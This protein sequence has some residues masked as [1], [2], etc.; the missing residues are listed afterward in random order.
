[1]LMTQV[2]G[3]PVL[4]DG[5]WGEGMGLTCSSR[6]GQLLSLLPAARAP[7]ADRMPRHVKEGDL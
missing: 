3:W 7:G 6:A 5:H 4:L 2:R 1:M